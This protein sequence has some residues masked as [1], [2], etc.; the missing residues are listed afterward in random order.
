MLTAMHGLNT[1]CNL[2]MDTKLY[3]ELISDYEV[4]L[5]K[6]KTRLDAHKINSKL[7]TDDWLYERIKTFYQLAAIGLDLLRVV[8]SYQDHR[9]PLPEKSRSKFSKIA[10]RS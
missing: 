10:Y 1:V 2:R 7:F 9:A 6:H 4:A 3:L 5:F 8:T